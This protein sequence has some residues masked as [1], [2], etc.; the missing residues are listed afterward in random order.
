V[1]DAAARRLQADSR[2]PLPA[3]LVG[4]GV[5]FLL[6]KVMRGRG[7]KARKALSPMHHAC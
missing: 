7:A 4:L 1:R 5:G 3:L 6:A 2:Y